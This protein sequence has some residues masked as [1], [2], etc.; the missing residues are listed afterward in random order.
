LHPNHIV[1]CAKEKPAPKAEKPKEPVKE[2][3][4]LT[5]EEI[6]LAHINKNP[7]GVRVSDMEGPLKETRMRIGFVAKQLLDE[8]KVLKMENRY[9]PKPSKK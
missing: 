3:K 7:K 2:E 9:Y 5:L 8:G 6:V 1:W 4:E